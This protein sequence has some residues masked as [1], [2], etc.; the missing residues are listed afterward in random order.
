M[1]ALRLP[2]GRMSAPKTNDMTPGLSAE[3]VVLNAPDKL[4][5]GYHRWVTR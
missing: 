3:G 2:S 5:S 4:C 1:N